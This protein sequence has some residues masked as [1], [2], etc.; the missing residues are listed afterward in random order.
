MAGYP[1][2]LELSGRHCLVVGGGA[3]AL[4]K[5]EG[6]LSFGACV[7]VVSPNVV[8]EL[9][10]LASKEEVEWHRRSY[11]SDDL[12]G[13]VL[14]ISATDDMEMNRRVAD[15]AHEFGIPVNVVDQPDLCSFTVPAVVRRGDLV[16]AIQTGGQSPALS[17]RLRETLERQFGPEYGPYVAF[18]GRMRRWIHERFPDDPAA[19]Q[20][21]AS[22]L[23]GLDLIGL[24]A[25][26]KEDRAE[27]EAKTCILSSLD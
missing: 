3:V 6:L 4:R 12:K 9:D 20:K 16:I 18:L 2:T 11:E 7:R 1:I 8:E 13:M 17:R 21:A 23:A 25:E 5:V 26:G 15:D 14:V 24:F 22:R 27:E 10:V 19:R